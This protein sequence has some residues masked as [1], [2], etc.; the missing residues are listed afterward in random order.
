M[1]AL[2]EDTR[3]GGESTNLDVLRSAAVIFVVISHLPGA[4]DPLRRWW[5]VHALGMLGVIIFFVHTCLVLMLS[6]ERQVTE[7]GEQ[8]VASVF[9]VRRAFRIYPLSIAVVLLTIGVAYALKGET[10]DIPAAL[11]NLLLVQNLTGHV[12]M[13]GPLWSLPYELQMYLTLPALFFF[14]RRSGEAASRRVFLLWVAVSGIVLGIWALHLPHGLFAYIPC[15]LPGVLAYAQ[16]KRVERRWSPWWLYGYVAAIAVVLPWLVA[17]GVG[18]HRAVWPICLG[19]GLL[20]PRCRET[21]SRTT[22]AVAKKIATYSY[23]LYLLHPV[24]VH[25]AFAP[26]WHAPTIARWLAMTAGL[27][28]LPVVAYHLIEKP[29]IGFGRTSAARLATSPADPKPSL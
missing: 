6:L 16:S 18:L 9:L 15:F 10:T 14:V 22:G 20:I 21:S 5:D 2:P 23:G 8:K 12:S 26:Q 7:R 28:L 27:V 4:A 29:G 17:Q 24:S 25:L 11:A 19:L 13:P 3:I 1:S